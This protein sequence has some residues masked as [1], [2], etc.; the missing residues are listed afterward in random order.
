MPK[1]LF[2]KLPTKGSAS[3][4]MKVELHV[5][6]AVSWRSLDFGFRV[7]G[8]QST[9]PCN[10]RTLLLD[11]VPL[12]QD[13]TCSMGSSVTSCPHNLFS[14][15]GSGSLGLVPGISGSGSGRLLSKSLV[16]PI[17]K[18]SNTEHVLSDA[19]LSTRHK[20][21]LVSGKM[22]AIPQFLP[23]SDDLAGTLARAEKL[24]GLTAFQLRRRIENCVSHSALAL[25]SFQ[26]SRGTEM[27][28]VPTINF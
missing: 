2:T 10:M 24:P 7:L 1:S 21:K 14:G 18:G 9:H 15:S 22:S 12:N 16:F 20:P 4:T 27:P 23:A 25:N 3:W 28:Q 19:E 5:A 26:L 17:C 11:P 8:P 13:F 6:S